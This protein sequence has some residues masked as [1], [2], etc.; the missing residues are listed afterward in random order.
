[1]IEVDSIESLE[2][3]VQ[4]SETTVRGHIFQGMNIMNYEQQLTGKTFASCTF[5]GC[6]MSKDFQSK[7]L[8][9]SQENTENV[10]IPQLQVPFNI[11]RSRMYTR[12][13][14]YAHKDNPEQPSDSVENS[15]DHEIF[16]HYKDSGKSTPTSAYEALARRLHDHAITDALQEHLEKFNEKTVI[17]IMGGHS[18]VPR[19][20]VYY[21]ETAK[22][23]KVLADQEYVVVSGGGPGAMEAVHLGTWFKGRP[24]SDLE[25]AFSMLERKKGSEGHEDENEETLSSENFN[26][27]TAFEV[28]EKYPHLPNVQYNDVGIPTW[29]YGHEP[30]TPFA[31]H[32]AK[33]FDNSVREDG[34]LAIA[35]GGVIY[36]PGSAGTIQEV[37]QD[38]A[39]N[40]YSSF[41]Y[42]SPMI[43]FG[44]RYWTED[45]PVYPL[46]QKL[47]PWSSDAYKNKP[48]LLQITSF[49]EEVLATLRRFYTPEPGPRSRLSSNPFAIITSSSGTGR[50]TT[51]SSSSRPKTTAPKRGAEEEAGGVLKK[52][53]L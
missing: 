34:L 16:N 26:F 51:L 28:V 43:F 36:A 32:I 42:P 45:K 14:L 41:G 9:E 4:S 25:S 31:S 52:N 24:L 39:Q 47:T 6:K 17:G 8:L 21:H 50:G 23:A 1:M 44:E 22:L 12:E 10:V 5:I 13:E 37:F 35:K 29:T 30:P 40:Y 18:S 27:K 20:S 48:Y 49:S 46:V 19:G 15:F 53:K 7:L 11:Q 2:K 33:Y 38:F 3:I